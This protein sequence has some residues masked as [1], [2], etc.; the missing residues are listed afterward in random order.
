MTGER[1]C[2]TCGVTVNDDTVLVYA[3]PGIPMSVGNC[4]ECYRRGAYPL[5]VVEANTE[6]IGGLIDAADWWK[7]AITY[8]HGKYLTVAEA[9]K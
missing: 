9:F 3:L 7:E 1:S 5:Y 8:K 2:E 6:G 4:A